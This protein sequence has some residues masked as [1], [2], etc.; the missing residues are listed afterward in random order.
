MRLAGTRV[1]DVPMATRS[2]HHGNGNPATQEFHYPPDSTLMSVTDPRGTITYA[3]TAFVDVSGYTR[4][5]LTGRPHNIVRH[6]DMPRDAFADL[7]ATL[8]RGES[9]TALVKNLRANGCEHYWV[10]AN[11]APIRS[12]D[13]VVGYLSVRTCPDPEE[14]AAAEALYREFREGR[15]QRKL[16]FHKGLVVRRNPLSLSRLW[17]TLSVRSAVRLAMAAV[18]S[19]VVVPAAVVGGMAWPV[20][21]VGVVAAL[22]AA[23]FLET[24]I[25]RPM[26]R[27]RDQAIGV[28]AGVVDPNL[29]MN[30]VDEIGM[31]AR[32]L[33]QAGLNLRALIGDVASQ[34]QGMQHNNEQI[35]QG[36][37]D[38]KQRTLRTYGHLHET[39]A[40]AEE[41]AVAAEHY[42][43]VAASV[44]ELAR[45]ANGSVEQGGEAISKVVATMNEL[46]QAN[47][48]IAEMNRLVDSIASQTNLLALNAAVEAARA[49]EAGRGFAVVAAEVRN[50]AQRSAEAALEIRRLV[51]ASVRHGELGTRQVEDAGAR[52]QEIVSR[53]AEV[54]ALASEMSSNIA[55]QSVGVQQLSRAVE[56]I[57]RMTRENGDA[58]KQF[59]AA[60]HGTIRRTDRLAEAVHAFDRQRDLLAP[61]AQREKRRRAASLAE[62]PGEAYS[63]QGPTAF[64]PSS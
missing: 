32:S 39:M 41:M 60:V 62:D 52:M 23:V 17:Q 20:A 8:H 42:A 16:A 53:V 51:E 35:L 19:A 58:A 63:L 37:E 57:D 34:I 14:T 44:H 45:A 3:N 24:R 33:N 48:R 54:D 29:R 15:A 59:A 30:R 25:V 64:L 61:V 21:A 36:N 18:A 4:D 9:W 11:V 28:A 56:E 10:R 5:Q 1:K 27:L 46:A 22:A 38:L 7:W 55:Q 50:L 31:I 49:G 47:H 12:G 26:S 6:P 43:E 2:S 13:T 40:V